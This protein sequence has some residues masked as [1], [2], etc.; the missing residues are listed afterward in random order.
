MLKKILIT[1]CFFVSLQSIAQ[2]D[3]QYVKISTAKHK[4]FSYKVI[5]MDRGLSGKKIN[6]KYFAAKD[7]CLQPPQYQVLNVLQKHLDVEELCI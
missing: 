1:F 6:A 4:G 7:Y 2:Y 3:K 5:Y